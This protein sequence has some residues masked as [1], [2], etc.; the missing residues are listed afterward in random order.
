MNWLAEYWWCLA[1]AAVAGH[2]MGF[3]LFAV[4]AVAGRIRVVLVGWLLHVLAG[5]MWFPVLVGLICAIIRWA[6]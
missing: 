5:L 2:L 3:V 6:K 1:I 4:G